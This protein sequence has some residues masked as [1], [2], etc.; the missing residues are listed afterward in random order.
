MV[1]SA[2]GGDFAGLCGVFMMR[3]VAMRS[4]CRSWICDAT[5][6]VASSA[7]VGTRWVKLL[8]TRMVGSGN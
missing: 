4:L 8:R 2:V 3:I 1:E 5:I 6:V 7:K